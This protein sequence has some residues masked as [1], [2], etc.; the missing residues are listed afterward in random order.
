MAIVFGTV[1]S[2]LSQVVPDATIQV[3]APQTNSINGAQTNLIGVVG[4]ASWGPLNKPVAASDMSS[5]QKA[6]GSVSTNKHDLLTPVMT[7]VL[8]GA[9]S[10]SLSRVSDGTDTAASSTVA[11]NNAVVKAYH[12]GSLGNQVVVSISPGTKAAS[13]R[14]QVS[15]PGL[16]TEVYDN[17]PSDATF[18]PTLANAAATG[19]GGLTP[20]ALISVVADA[21]NTNTV[22]V[23]STITLSGGTDGAEGVTASTVLGTDSAVR[24]G[25]FSLRGTG[26]S[27]VVPSDMDDIANTWTSTIAFGQSEGAMP[28]LAGPSG[29]AEAD[30]AALMNAAGVDTPAIEPLFGDLLAVNDTYN[31]LVRLVS[32]AGFVA[33]LVATLGP[34][35]SPLNKPLNGVVGSQKC[36][37]ASAG[38]VNAYSEAELAQIFQGRMDVVTNPAPGGSYWAV[39]GGINASSDS[40]TNGV[41]YTRMTN[42]VAKSLDLVAGKWVGQDITPGLMI[43]VEASLA[44]LGNKM[45]TSGILTLNADGSLPYSAICDKTNNSQATISAGYLVASF[46]VTYESIDRFMTVQ[47][48]G[49][50]TVVTV[51]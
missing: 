17:L 10:F 9:N 41:N 40:D 35:E 16:A 6:F 46:A 43:A 27:L 25:L 44:A 8:Q 1:N 42:Y 20:S 31:G 13:T 2:T 29:M 37:L 23:P 49:G 34:N 33:G 30:A 24:T 22:V 32:P 7:A 26:V 19:V 38:S 47:V 4:S 12:T 5:A 15:I 14:A 3:I 45:L 21:T 51:N 39:R 50:Q 28:I 36:G 11:T 48:Q 18:W